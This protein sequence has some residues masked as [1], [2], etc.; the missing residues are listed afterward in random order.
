L[1]ASRCHANFAENVPIALFLASVVDLNGGNRNVLGGSLAALLLRILHI[2]LSL[3]GP[4][5]MS[6]GLPT[7]SYGTLG[8]IGG[9]AG[10]A[11][12]LVKGYWGF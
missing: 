2:E 6:G 10:Y 8:L 4:K 11:T 12:Y 3:V 5:A 7:D 9:M 1:V